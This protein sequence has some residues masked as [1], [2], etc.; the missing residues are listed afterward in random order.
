MN[1]LAL[2]M[3]STLSLMMALIFIVMRILN[4]MAALSGMILVALSGMILVALNV[5]IPERTFFKMAGL[6]LLTFLPL[7][8]TPFY[9]FLLP[10]KQ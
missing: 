5:I 8:L 2:K 1:V 3:T 9:R 7:I 4:L 6:K 10:R